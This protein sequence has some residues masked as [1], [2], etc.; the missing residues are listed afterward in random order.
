MVIGNGS[1]NSQEAAAILGNSARILVIASRRTQACQLIPPAALR[2]PIMRWFSSFESNPRLDS[3]C[4]AAAAAQEIAADLI[5][6]LGGGSAIDVAKA[7]SVLPPEPSRALATVRSG[8]QERWSVAQNSPRVLAVPTLA[9]SGAEVT[10]FATLYHEGRKYSVDATD[11][12]PDM[13][14][15]DPAL[16]LTAPHCPTSAAALDAVCHAIESAWSRSATDGSRQHS[17]QAL[18]Y[19]A[20]ISWR[21]DSSYSIEERQL[22]ALGAL[23]AG[24]AINETRTT[25]AHAAAYP[26][27]VRFGIP[28]GVACAL[29]MQWVAVLNGPAVEGAPKVRSTIEGALGVPIGELPAYFGDRLH[30]AGWPNRLREYGVDRSHLSEIAD[31]ASRQSRMANNPASASQEEIQDM[32]ATIL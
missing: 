6:G 22:L 24:T 32:L 14:I 10:Q 17:R 7:A 19:L 8:G 25:A 3:A 2:T 29:N 31:E 16:A 12:R 15:V 1:L 11:V 20:E 4:R 21:P 28:H 18:T 30:K 5:I 9:G 13:A 26:L 27:T 23:H